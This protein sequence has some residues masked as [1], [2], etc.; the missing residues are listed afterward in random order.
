MVNYNIDFDRERRIGLP[1]VVYGSEKSLEDLHKI[2]EHY[3]T[4]GKNVLVTKLQ[5]KK[6]IS[7]T[8][9]YP[10]ATFDQHSGVFILKSLKE[11]SE[12]GEVAIISAGT[13]D[14]HVMNEAFYA[15]YF[16]GIKAERI[17][18]VGVAGIHRLLD[19]IEELKAYKVLIVV[20][21]FEGALPTVV[22]GL[23]QQ[24]IIAVPTAVGYGVAKGGRVALNSMLTSCASGVTVMNINNGYGAAMAAIRIL[25]LIKR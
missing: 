9:K 6:A 22:G 14:V 10:K 5:K 12:S 18:D 24:P 3:V 1:E 20:A 25:N 7:L 21:G 4:N 13:S 11:I 19:K 8:R 16:M 17:N 23:L 15:L 2:L